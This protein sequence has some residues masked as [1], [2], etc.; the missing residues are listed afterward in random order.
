MFLYH[1]QLFFFTGINTFVYELL[2]TDD[3][4][5]EIQSHK[6]NKTTSQKMWLYS[7]IPHACISTILPALSAWTAEIQMSTM[8]I[9]TG[10]LLNNLIQG[11]K[12]PQHAQA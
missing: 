6:P 2:C 5:H 8:K 10:E 1:I 11:R 3:V 12:H 9:F 4:L 7:F